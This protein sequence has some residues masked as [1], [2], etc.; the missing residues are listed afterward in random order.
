MQQALCSLT[1]YV[2]RITRKNVEYITYFKSWILDVDGKT[3]DCIAA[4]LR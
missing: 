1:M 2:S 4:T 3:E